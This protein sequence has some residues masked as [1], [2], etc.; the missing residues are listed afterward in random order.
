MLIARLLAWQNNTNC[1]HAR[2]FRRMLHP[3][4]IKSHILHSDDASTLLQSPS[5]SWLD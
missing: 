5:C 3:I 1:P 4:L 2:W